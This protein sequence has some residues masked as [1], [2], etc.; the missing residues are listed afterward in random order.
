MGVDRSIDSGVPF[1]KRAA[2]LMPVGLPDEPA[3]AVSTL[4]FCCVPARR[5]R[6]TRPNSAKPQHLRRKLSISSGDTRTQLMVWSNE[7]ECI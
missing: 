1:G 3:T 6:R 7:V 2:V 5:A 4:E